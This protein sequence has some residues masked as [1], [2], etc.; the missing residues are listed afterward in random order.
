MTHTCWTSYGITH[1]GKQRKTNQD[2]FLSLPDKQLW[3]VADGMGGHDAGEFASN[4]LAQALKSFE[5]A[6]T[7]GSTVLKLNQI[8]AKVNFTLINVASESNKRIIGSTVVLL[9]VWNQHSVC[10]WSG[11]SRIYLF[12]KGKLKQLSRDHNYASELLAQGRSAEEV[13]NQPF[14]GTLT[15]AI[16]GETNLYLETQIQEI[17]PS[18]IFLL[19][20]DGLNKEV[21]DLEI[22]SILNTTN[23]KQAA[24]QL[25]EVTLTRGARDNVTMV[26]LTKTGIV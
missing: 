24:T 9:L 4:S 15:H 20:S 5:P 19:C 17:R 3:M 18:D 7:L 2:T 13:N 8:L 11:D 14:L 22:E 25:L 16:G 1:I 23:I 12:R 21:T 6:K 26:I 10:L